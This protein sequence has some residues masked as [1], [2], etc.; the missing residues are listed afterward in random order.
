MFFL[1]KEDLIFELLLPGAPSYALA[2]KPQ[3]L[4]LFIHV[5]LIICSLFVVLPAQ[6]GVDS[7]FENIME[8]IDHIKKKW[9][10]R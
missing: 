10:V 3:S 2:S 7:L 9:D 1:I 6:Y 4:S 5:I 8:L